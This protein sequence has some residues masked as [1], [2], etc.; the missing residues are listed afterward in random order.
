MAVF[1]NSETGQYD[2]ASQSL[3]PIEEA[4]FLA[5]EA[6]LHV[7]TGWHEYSSIAAMNAAVAANHWPKPQQNNNPISAAQ[8]SAKG[9][10]SHAAQ[11]A[12]Q[13]IPGLGGI[14]DFFQ[15][16]TQKATWERVG[17]VTVG[18]IILYVGLKSISTP[19]GGNP[20]R[21]TVKTTAKRAIKLVK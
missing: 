21:E 13:L 7:G 1:Y 4:A 9:V 6:R 15:R 2:V 17:E 3:N 16:I 11:Q 14:A 18:V 12:T 19:R 8:Q 20:A 5:N 10:A